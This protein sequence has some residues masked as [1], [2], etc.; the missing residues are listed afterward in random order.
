MSSEIEI[1][2]LK[3]ATTAQNVAEL[4]INKRIQF[5]YAKNEQNSTTIK[6]TYSPENGLPS[7]FSDEIKRNVS[8]Y[9][10]AEVAASQ[11]K[12]LHIEMG[13]P[14][15]P[16]LEMF[17]AKKDNIQLVLSLLR[18]Y[19]AQNFEIVFDDNTCIA[20]INEIKSIAKKISAEEI[21]TLLMNDSTSLEIKSTSLFRI[22]SHYEDKED[23]K[24]TDARGGFPRANQPLQ[25]LLLRY[26][27]KK[28]KSFSSENSIAVPE[29]KQSSQSDP[30]AL[31]NLLLRVTYFSITMIRS[32]RET[33]IADLSELIAK[34]SNWSLRHAPTCRHSDQFLFYSQDAKY[35]G[36]Q[37]FRQVIDKKQSI[38]IT[39]YKNPI[40]GILNNL[41]MVFVNMLLAAPAPISSGSSAFFSLSR[42]APLQQLP[43]ADLC[44]WKEDLSHRPPEEKQVFSPQASMS[45]PCSI[46]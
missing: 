41:A 44:R 28:T 35:D 22:L 23:K 9:L 34:S 38:K 45:N 39:D 24:N 29:L 20:L 12:E 13:Y 4:K 27:V 26:Q 15:V 30:D 19:Q 36:Y 18:Y 16:F 40:L 11:L 10:E 33:F 32:E 43:V 1:K 25:D 8:K 5:S 6:I 7:V 46:S 21:I 31:L 37:Q 2:E 14:K 17:D 42:T 3:K